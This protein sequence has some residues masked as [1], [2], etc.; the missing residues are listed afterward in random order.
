MAG[1]SPLPSGAVVDPAACQDTDPDA[2]AAAATTA[3]RRHE[4]PAAME[5]QERAAAEEHECAI[6]AA[7]NAA[8]AC[9]VEVPGEP[10]CSGCAHP[11]HSRSRRG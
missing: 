9:A 2:I 1:T 7:R 6:Q 8:L 5:E 3:P 10:R 11:R 4:D